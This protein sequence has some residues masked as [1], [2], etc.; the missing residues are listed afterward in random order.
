MALEVVAL[1]TRVHTI[2]KRIIL[3]ILIISAIPLSLD[4]QDYKHEFL[5]SYGVYPNSLF[6]YNIHCFSGYSSSGKT[7]YY[8]NKHLL[9]PLSFDYYN[10]T[11]RL[12][13]F[14][15]SGVFSDT[16][17]DITGTDRK[18]WIL[19]STLLAGTKLHWLNTKYLN[20]YSKLAL[21]VAL[22]IYKE[23]DVPFVLPNFQLSLL[24]MEVM[25]TRQF[26]IF[27]EAGVGE[28]G[29]VHGGMCFKM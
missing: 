19:N 23:I 16:C 14:G 15:F 27:A 25:F 18:A 11:S 8:S 12:W 26:G 1:L 29:I 24:G 17:V 7:G 21:G 2:M 20:M 5:A 3:S 22:S 6:Y 10:R 9:G 13:S 28:Q 4:A